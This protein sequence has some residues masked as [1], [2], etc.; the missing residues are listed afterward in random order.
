VKR[1]Q[2]PAG[3]PEQLAQHV[4]ELRLKLLDLHKTLI[5]YERITYEQTF[6]AIKS[7]NQ[8]LQL[9]IEDP[10]FAWLHPLSEL[11]VQMDEMLEDDEPLTSTLVNRIFA[12]TRNLLKASEQGQGF[13]RSY[14]EALQ[15]GPDVVMAHASVM[16][17]LK[18]G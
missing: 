14:Y 8:F 11:V 6:G 1:E 2:H 17:C 5:E 13:G 3:P 15:G 9:L 18:L 16:K 12:E 7:P 4:K 10:W